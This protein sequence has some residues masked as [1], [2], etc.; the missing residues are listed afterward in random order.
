MVP[1]SL[2]FSSLNFTE[3]LHITNFCFIKP[4]R[5]IKFI[6]NSCE[7]LFRKW[8]VLYEQWMREGDKI[9]GRRSEYISLRGVSILKWNGVY[10]PVTVPDDT[11]LRG[12]RG[13]YINDCSCPGLNNALQNLSGSRKRKSFLGLFA[14]FI[15]K[16]KT[17]IYKETYK[18]P[19]SVLCSDHLHEHKI[20]KYRHPS[21]P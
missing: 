15:A 2:F 11:A 18:S 6:Y 19:F 12:K 4:L 21:S 1:A 3:L 16:Q 20:H 7:R 10:L 8:L 5:D 14:N 17:I 13:E 9:G